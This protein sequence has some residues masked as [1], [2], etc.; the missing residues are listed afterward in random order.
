MIDGE[1]S[2]I[3]TDKDGNTKLLDSNAP[4]AG[5]RPKGIQFATKLGSGFDTGGFT[6]SRLIDRDNI[7]AN[8]LDGIQIV[9]AS[10]DTAYEGFIGSMPRSM[11][12]SGHSL[13]VNTAGWMASAADQTFRQIF[14]DRDLSQWGPVSLV[15]RVANAAL[16]Y[17]NFDPTGIP[18]QATPSVRTVFTGAWAAGGLPTCGAMYDAGPDNAIGSIYYEWTRGA[19]VS[20]GG[21]PNFTW[22]VN[23]TT[24]D[25]VASGQDSTADLQAAGPGTGTLTTTATRRFAT[26]KLEYG[27]AGGTAGMEYT[28]DWRNL[29]VRGN[30]GLPSLGAAQPYGVGASDV[31]E[32]LV[33][34]YCPW[35]NTGG[36]KQTTYPIGHLVFRDETS[37]YDAM[38][39]VNS[40]HLWNLAVWENR[41][42]SY[43]Q[44]DLSD[45]DWEIRHD[46]VGNQIGL[47][48]DEYTNLRN[49]LKV[50]YQDVA[51]GRTELLHYD[52]HAE[53]RDDSV[54][55]PFNA[56]GR[57]R[58]GDPFVVPY[59]TTLASA[60]ELGRLRLLEDNQV[61][62]PGSFTVQG[63]IKDRSGVYQ[64]VWKVRAGDRIRLT[65]SVS[66]SD[67]PRLVAETSYSHDSQ[68]ITI[69]VDSTLRF[70][71]AYLDRTATALQAANLGG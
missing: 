16:G 38:L 12:D 61:K 55:N 44:I 35:L 66:L 59:P 49:R 7:D 1:L 64:P 17:A 31:I 48:G 10:G 52:D 47:Q 24:S 41:T 63:R 6:L 28:I 45:W 30:H 18:D 67:R 15:Q 23:A 42:L 62:A 22:A 53:L 29:T 71:E 21:D 9:S 43:A 4:N 5:D 56:H 51:T 32:W 40:Y 34:T 3:V 69:G 26:V 46:E 65:S 27:V 54:D 37:V 70:I 58:S 25:N 57:I 36:V 8:L 11:D 33:G 13:T 19:N 14:V 68:S 60:L 50:Q 39:K 20:T 2:V